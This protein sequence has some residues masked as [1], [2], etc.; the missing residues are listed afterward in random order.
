MQPP[1]HAAIGRINVVVLDELNPHACRSKSVAA[2]GFGKKTA[3]VSVPGR[4]NQQETCDIE[5]LNLHAKG[6]RR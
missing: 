6:S 2:I 1:Q 5:P 4:R 3:P